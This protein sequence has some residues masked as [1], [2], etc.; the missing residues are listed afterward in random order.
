MQKPT[1]YGD[2]Q[3]VNTATDNDQ[4]YSRVIGLEGGGYVVVWQSHLAIN[5]PFT[6]EAQIFDPAGN[7]VGGQFTVSTDPGTNLLPDVAAVAGGGFAVTWSGSEGAVHGAVFDATG[8]KQGTEFIASGILDPNNPGVAQEGHLASL[9][10]GGFVMA[11]SSNEADGLHV[12]I[13]RFDAAGNK[14]GAL[15]DVGTDAAGTLE[16]VRIAD[17]GAGRFGVVWASEDA[18]FNI[19]GRVYNY[20]GTAAT[21]SFPIAELP[22]QQ[23]F[24]EIAGDGTGNFLVT[25]RDWGAN[26]AS[27]PYALIGQRFDGH[28]SPIPV[29]GN[30]P[31]QTAF[32][33]SDPNALGSPPVYE[34]VTI[35]LHTGGFL[36]VFIKDAAGSHV[37]VGQLLASDGN[38]VGDQFIV[39]Q[40]AVQGFLVLE[41]SA[42]E[43][44]DG[45]VVVT[46]EDNSTDSAD[47]N[48]WGV[49]S[50]VIDPRGGIISGT[51]HS[52]TLYG[53][54]YGQQ[55]ADTIT[56]LGGD[57]HIYAHDGDDVVYGGEGNDFID[58][59]DGIDTMDGGNGNDTFVVGYNSVNDILIEGI[60]GGADK[61]IVQGNFTLNAGA[62]VETLQLDNVS[63][64]DVAGNE[65]V[66]TLIAF[67]A[68]V[69]STMR[70]GGGNDVLDASTNKDVKML[71]G[72]GD[73]TYVIHKLAQLANIT[74]LAGEGNDTIKSYLDLT[75]PAGEIENLTLLG[76]AH[77]GIGSAANNK[78]IGNTGND[79]LE[80]GNGNDVLDG[81]E[82]TDSLDGGAGNDTFVLGDGNDKVIDS[83]GVDTITSTISR[84]LA[85][86]TTIENL[87]LGGTN[88]T[89]GTGNDLNN[90][91][92]GN[93]GNNA[94]KGGNGNDVLDGKAGADIL[95]GGAGNDTFV[96]ADG[97]D[98]VIDS[99]G[100]DTIT[101]TIS[102]SLANYT[103]IEKLKL[104]GTANIN[105]TGNDLNNVLF[106]NA[107]N[108]AL[109]G[110]NG[111]DD[112]RG[113]DGVD[114][115]TGGA[116][117]DK[118]TFL[119][120]GEIGTA[121]GLRDIVTD[122]HHAQDKIVLSAIDAIAGTGANDAFAFLAQ[123]GHAFTGAKGQL[124]WD[125]QDHAGTANDVT[126]VSGDINGDKVADFTIQ[127]TGLVSLTQGDFVL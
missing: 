60:N 22:D 50:Q 6:I 114:K 62:Y 26:V 9:S 19:Y 119:T 117:N 49:H 86:Y 75:L 120:V 113:G 18:D 30:D 43:L 109:N 116:G 97:N 8:V 85:G 45:R 20:D 21:A 7:A 35:G 17:L 102:R 10:T 13:Q 46:W 15:I 124:V 54:V 16:H 42:A 80:G 107:G 40:S 52:E 123:E 32:E 47:A 24:P 39:K 37:I 48:G 90:V 56:A 96:L 51:E 87:K 5:T 122:F 64:I 118:F 81:K 115:L 71:G 91:L 1:P 12:L 25:Y 69:V 29:G 2:E 104:V 72:T 53:S 94:L 73:D 99:S 125:Q 33:I 76:N 3:L 92:T 41:V 58:G 79:T 66:N 68:D 89:N 67:G 93:S 88:N 36:S 44:A 98:K 27:D 126:L 38:P 127:L 112:L 61:A 111:N 110:G 84:S 70:G 31:A 55:I 100:S 105:G 101:S 65:L 74:E 82:G 121:S 59:D 106:G 78:L 108:N 14:L 95:N 57:D 34:P 11:Y 28:N 103:M 63:F 4:L 83:A 77:H 23:R